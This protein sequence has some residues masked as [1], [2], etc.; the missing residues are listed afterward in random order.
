[1]LIIASTW[2]FVDA[3]AA[4]IAATLAFNYF[5][6]PPVGTFT[7]AE[8]ANW[9]ALI[10]FFIAS[11]VATRLVLRERMQ[12]RKR[13]QEKKRNTKWTFYVRNSGMTKSG[14]RL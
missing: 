8:P 6:F 12:N 10:S 11:I 2:G 4:S 13:C 3:L 9:I 14:A 5:F 1:M 7:I